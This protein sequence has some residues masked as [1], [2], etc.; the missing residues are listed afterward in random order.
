MRS[1]VACNSD[2]SASDNKFSGALVNMNLNTN[3]H[4]LVNY[5]QTSYSELAKTDGI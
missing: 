1:L 5:L 4:P 3:G 2:S